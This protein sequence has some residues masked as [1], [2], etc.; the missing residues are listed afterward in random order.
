MKIGYPCINLALD[1]SGSKTFRLK[2]YSEQRLTETVENNL[3]C[4]MRILEF[5]VKHRIAFFRISSDLIPFAS[6]PINTYNWQQHFRDKFEEIGDFI[7]KNEMRISMHPDQFTLINSLKE[8][9]FQRSVRE[10]AYHAELLDLMQLDASAKIQIH[11]GG[12]Y[13]DK[14]ASM[15]RFAYRFSQ[16]EDSIRTR[17]VIENDDTLFNLD[18][19]LQ[20]N[21]E[22]GV[23]VLLDVFHHRV[24]STSATVSQALKLTQKTWSGKKHGVPMVDYSSQRL[25][26]SPRAHSES[27]DPADFLS[28]LEETKPVDFDVMLEIKDKE[29]S[30]VKAIALASRD[31]RFADCLLS[32]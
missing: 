14:K 23:P 28:F 4:L 15:Q 30:A 3:G 22:T 25:D 7:K 31:P 24:N 20:I 26:G 1:C 11:V 12:V 10:L 29:K 2:S 18:D 16:I 13:Q 8:D 17:L 19:C 32:Y 27:I 9:I 21:E 6:H 5:N